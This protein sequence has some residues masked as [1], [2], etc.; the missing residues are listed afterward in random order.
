MRDGPNY[1]IRRADFTAPGLTAGAEGF[2]TATTGKVTGEVR[3]DNL[4]RIVEGF[5]GPATARF[6]AGASGPTAPWAVQATVDAPGGT[7]LR[8]DGTAARTLDRVDLKVRGEVPLGL[9]NSF[10]QPRSVSG[11]ASLDLRVSGPPALASVSGRIASSD[12]RFVDPGLGIVLENVS[13]T[14]ALSASRAQLDVTAP[15]QGGGRILVTGPVGLTRPYAGDLRVTFENAR[16]RDPS[17]YDTTVSGTITLSGPLTGGAN[18]AGRLALGQTEI[19]IP[20]SITGG[21]APIPNI[22]HIAESAPV[23]DTRIR[24]GLIGADG[25]TPGAENDRGPV[26]GLDVRIDALNEIFIRGRGLDA[27]LGGSLR[28]GGTTANVIPSG[29]FELIRGRLDILGRRLVLDQGSITLQGSLDPFLFLSASSTAEGITARVVLAGNLSDPQLRFES[30]PELPED[31]VVAQLLFGRGINEISPFQAAQLAS[32]IAT[33]TGRGGEGILGSLRRSFG[34]D[35]LDVS[36]SESG[37]AAVTL[38]TYLTDNIYTDVVVS[39][40]RPATSI[41]IEPLRCYVGCSPGAGAD[42]SA[43]NH[44]GRCPVIHSR[45]GP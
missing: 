23:R 31:E 4:G 36:T 43:R 16:V 30:T 33:L 37:E 26:Y 38:G 10:I 1:T 44:G 29:Q 7:A 28:I 5:S 27:E 25:R 40:G 24:A 9:A 8:V 19:R 32:S 21:T 42:R 45:C 20:S 14:I 3:I 18:I 11:R 35:D 22:T 12:I 6:T 34:L 17:L 2:R 15:V 39:D 41:G 13:T